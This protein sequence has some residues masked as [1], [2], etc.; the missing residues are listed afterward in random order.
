[1]RGHLLKA[2][3]RMIVT[4]HVTGCLAERPS[5]GGS[6]GP[7]C[8]RGGVWGG[9]R[10]KGSR[11][12]ICWVSYSTAPSHSGKFILGE[13]IENNSV[14]VLQTWVADSE[15]DEKNETRD[16]KEG[17]Q[18]PF[19]DCLNSSPMI[20][21]GVGCVGRRWRYNNILRRLLRAWVGFNT[22]LAF[23]VNVIASRLVTLIEHQ[24]YARY[25]SSLEEVNAL[26][27]CCS[28]S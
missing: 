2:N 27:A 16:P 20:Y 14:C 6:A 18:N 9:G 5:A 11:N 23:L 19:S 24:L 26:N 25:A 21:S 28:R 4:G 17:P 22:G 7:Q 1:M 12:S 10:K 3:N 15:W 8:Q 13:E